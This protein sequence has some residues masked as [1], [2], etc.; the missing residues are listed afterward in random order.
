MGSAWSW[1]EGEAAPSGRCPPLPPHSPGGLPVGRGLVPSCPCPSLRAGL[2]AARTPLP[3][4]QIPSQ[5]HCYPPQ[6]QHLDFSKSPEVLLSAGK[7]FPD[8]EGISEGSEL[9]KNQEQRSCE[10]RERSRQTTWCSRGPD[11]LHGSGA[12]V[13]T[14]CVLSRSGVSDCLPCPPPGDLPDPG[15]EPGSL[16]SPALAGGFLPLA[17]PGKP[18]SLST[19]C[20]KPP[21]LC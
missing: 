17:P 10:H 8:T 7:E 12:S 19:G 16:K 1:S 18:Q 5:P 15:I 14:L 2:P 11:S 20:L 3:P 21:D 6:S 4:S 13:Y 9:I